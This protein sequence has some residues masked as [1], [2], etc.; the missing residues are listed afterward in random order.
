MKLSC[1]HGAGLFLFFLSIFCFT[2]VA[3]AQQDAALGMSVLEIDEGLIDEIA[4]ALARVC[5]NDGCTYDELRSYLRAMRDRQALLSNE[6]FILNY[7]L[8]EN[9]FGGFAK[10]RLTFMFKLLE[11]LAAIADVENLSDEELSRLGKD[12]VIRLIQRG[13]DGRITLEELS[14]DIGENEPVTESM[15]ILLQ[16]NSGSAADKFQIEF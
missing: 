7:L 5:G 2:P 11:L 13:I 9:A 6:R 16:G 14:E 15:S 8:N 12:G 1:P 10:N 4:E 3:E